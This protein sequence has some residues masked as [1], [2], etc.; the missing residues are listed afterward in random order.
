MNGAQHNPIPI[1][2]QMK[3][4]VILL[5]VSVLITSIQ[6]Q[7]TPA[8]LSGKI[9][10]NNTG[11]AITAA[12]IRILTQKDSTLVTGTSST[13]E[14]TFL[15]PL[16]YGNYIVNISF[17]GYTP[18]FQHI[19]LSS[20]RPTVKLDTIKLREESILL[21]EAV[22]TAVPAE[23]QV[24]GDTPL[25]LKNALKSQRYINFKILTHTLPKNL[26]QAQE[27]VVKIRR[28]PS[29]VCYFYL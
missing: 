28:Y 5:L 7:T 18:F 8:T 15:I 19:T 3:K 13:R 29:T 9:I 17:V 14:G 6:A 1:Y 12:T 26:S 11:E 16:N 25:S 2:T 22:V 20:A 4:T 24:K 21:N 10:D 27:R 23:I